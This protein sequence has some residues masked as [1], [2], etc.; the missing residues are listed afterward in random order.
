MIIKSARISLLLA[1]MFL[2]GQVASEE[3]KWLHGDWLLTYDPDG[4]TQD[5]LSFK[6]GS[7]FITTEVATGKQ[8]K[9]MY[10]VRNKKIKISLLKNG[11]VFY[12]FAL[13]FDNSK[14]KLYYKDK[15]S[16]TISYY[17]RVK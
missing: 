1:L 5:K 14:D 2:S 6:K 9:G 3:I 11:K 10:T 15:D 8:Y 16:N 12:K 17:T 4:D 7:Q 13:T